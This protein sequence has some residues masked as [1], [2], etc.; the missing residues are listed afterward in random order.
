MELWA[1]ELSEAEKQKMVEDIGQ[2]QMPGED[3]QKLSKL[4]RECS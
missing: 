2:G 4:G 3:L 1:Q